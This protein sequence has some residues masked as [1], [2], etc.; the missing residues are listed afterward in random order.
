MYMLIIGPGKFHLTVVGA[1]EDADAHKGILLTVRDGERPSVPSN[2]DSRA[3]AVV[4]MAR[5][6][7]GTYVKQTG[8]R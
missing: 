8:E 3:P 7:M 2:V 5:T 1:H 4:P 6:P